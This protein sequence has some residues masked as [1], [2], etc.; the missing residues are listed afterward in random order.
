MLELG[1]LL[2]SA[3]HECMN[4]LGDISMKMHLVNPQ[5]IYE[6]EFGQK[7]DCLLLSNIIEVVD[8]YHDADDTEKG[9][10]NRDE[11]FDP[12]HFKVVHHH[13]D[14]CIR[15]CKLGRSQEIP[16]SL[17]VVNVPCVFDIKH[18]HRN[19]H[20]KDKVCQVN[21]LDVV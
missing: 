15:P 19:S 17:R 11:N 13:D 8:S 14:I 10:G 6:H 9:D 3:N 18:S 1:L 7:G 2:D 21:H 4:L 5:H 12:A 20:C 16:I